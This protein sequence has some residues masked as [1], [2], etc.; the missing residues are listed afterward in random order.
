MN[1]RNVPSTS[2]PQGNGPGR[3]VSPPDPT[4]DRR[5]LFRLVGGATALAGLA[6]TGGLLVPE[7]AE[8]ADG[9]PDLYL[10]GTDGWMSLPRSPAIAP[11]HPDVLAPA[12]FT[13]YIFGFRNVTGIGALAGQTALTPPVLIA[14]LLAWTAAPLA[15]AALVFSRREL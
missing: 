3:A 13:T 6:W 1:R 9:P 7:N 10:G 8:G 2:A 4:L 15:L 12:P 5:G 11:F 14:V